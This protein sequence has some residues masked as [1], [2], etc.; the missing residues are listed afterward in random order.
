MAEERVSVGLYSSVKG[1]G[2]SIDFP[3]RSVDYYT[4]S[5]QADMFECFINQGNRI[6][7]KAVFCVNHVFHRTQGRVPFSFH[8]GPGVST[9]WCPDFDS[10]YGIVLALAG[11]I[12]C[13]AEFDAGVA[14]DIGFTLELGGHLRTS[15]GVGFG[16]YR[17]GLYGFPAPEIRIYWMFK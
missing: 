9:G 11:N 10:T 12:G 6:G 14:I 17:G 3:S 16:W 1:F 15:D 8:A 13:R 7:G 4:L 2:A 5:L